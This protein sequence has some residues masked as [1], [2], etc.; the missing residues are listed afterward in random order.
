M[1][2]AARTIGVIA[3]SLRVDIVKRGAVFGV[4]RVHF[5]CGGEVGVSV[6]VPTALVLNAAVKIVPFGV[7]LVNR[8]LVKHFLRYF[9]VVVLYMHADLAKLGILVS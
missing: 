6:V 4:T 3:A 7:A 5:V 9:E 1:H 8:N 2:V